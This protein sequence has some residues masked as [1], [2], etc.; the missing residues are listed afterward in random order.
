MVF[1]ESDPL[2][3]YVLSEPEVRRRLTTAQLTNLKDH[4]AQKLS[5]WGEVRVTVRKGVLIGRK[6]S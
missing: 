2:I 3:A 1:R 4:V 5:A 6:K